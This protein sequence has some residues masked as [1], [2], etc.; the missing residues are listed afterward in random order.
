[1]MMMRSTEVSAR[2]GGM[3]RWWVMSGWSWGAERPGAEGLVV[4]FRWTMEWRVRRGEA[5]MKGMWKT[6]AERLEV[7][8][9]C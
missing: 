8:F 4:G 5:S 7:G 2:R 9:G 1:M 3:V 6:L